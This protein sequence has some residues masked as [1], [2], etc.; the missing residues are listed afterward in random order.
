MQQT[1]FCH[2]GPFLSYDPPSKPKNQNFEKLKL[3]LRDIITL[4]L[5]TTNDNHMM[6]GSW[7]RDRQTFL[8]FWTSFCPPPP[9]LTTQK[10]KILK[11]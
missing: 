8:S 5:C 11:N 6:Y 4:H 7:E 1:I 3:R 2:F 10:I 9:P